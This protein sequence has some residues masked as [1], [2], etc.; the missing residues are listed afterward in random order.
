M[1]H[2]SG[3]RPFKS[4]K[5]KH[6]AGG[7]SPP[8]PAQ[9]SKSR[10][11]Y[12]AFEALPWVMSLLATAVELHFSLPRKTRFQLFMDTAIITNCIISLLLIKI[13]NHVPLY[14]WTL[15]RGHP[16]TSIER[17]AVWFC[18]ATFCGLLLISQITGIFYQCERPV[19]GKFMSFMLFQLI[20]LIVFWEARVWGIK[21][22][23]MW[24]STTAEPRHT[25]ATMIFTGFLAVSFTPWEM[26]EL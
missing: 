20:A 13:F 16:C 9:L 3:E 17:V 15:I 10:Y 7:Y 22:W 24:K 25:I 18:N 23:A 14:T 21:F 1:E 12:L 4:L 2:H 11:L 5:D 6:D 8:S 19:G 26:S